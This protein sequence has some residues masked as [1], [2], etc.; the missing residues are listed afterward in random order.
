MTGGFH[1]LTAF[2]EAVGSLPRLVALTELSIRAL[3]PP[4][5]PATI[6]V[7]CTA[8]TYVL[9]VSSGDAAMAEVQVG[10]A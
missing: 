8:E 1:E 2:I 6:S 4:R 10:G 5:P 3:D 9:D 7:I